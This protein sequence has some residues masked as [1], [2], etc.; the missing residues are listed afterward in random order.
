MGF[1]VGGRETR[2]ENM[3]GTIQ[4][5]NSVHSKTQK[6]DIQTPPPTFVSF[7]FYTY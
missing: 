2:F 7:T 6:Y 5:D 1:G 3:P 4:V